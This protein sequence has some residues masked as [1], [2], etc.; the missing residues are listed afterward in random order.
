MPDAAD[1]G[2]AADAPA[3]PAPE[4]DHGPAPE[5]ADAAVTVAITRRA[6]PEDAS[7]MPAWVHTPG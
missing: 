6:A 1:R 5:P 2:P 7:V 4:L 3:A